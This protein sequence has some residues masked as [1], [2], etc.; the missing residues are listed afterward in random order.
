MKKQENYLKLTTVLLRTN[1]HV[2]EVI[3]NDIISYELNT[4][5]F[6][7]M[8]VLYHKGKQPIQ[9]VGEKMLMANSSMTYVVDKLVKRGFISKERDENDRRNTL[10]DLTLEGKDFFMTIF[11]HHVETLTEIYDILTP[12]ETDELIKLLKK[13]GYHAKEIQGGKK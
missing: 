9:S 13:V 6:G 8:E 11:S 4:T 7:A 3:K 5:E 1:Q 2:T 12:N 10:I